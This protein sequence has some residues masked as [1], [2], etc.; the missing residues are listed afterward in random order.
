MMYRLHTNK[1]KDGKYTIVL[2]DGNG[3]RF[4]YERTFDSIERANHFINRV[5]HSLKKGIAINFSHWEETLPE[6][7]SI[8]YE[9]ING[10]HGMFGKNNNR[11]IA[12]Y[13]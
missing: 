13:S 12:E 6:L 11:Q 10:S 2:T 7:N 5:N 4:H 1:S 8:A 9:M 3:Y